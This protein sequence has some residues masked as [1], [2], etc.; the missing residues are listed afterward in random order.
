MVWYVALI[1]VLNIG[2]GYALAVYLGQ[3]AGENFRLPGA[4]GDLFG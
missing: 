4:D 1:A 3:A 2:L